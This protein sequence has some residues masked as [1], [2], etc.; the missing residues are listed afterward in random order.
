MKPVP[1]VMSVAEH[2]GW[3]HV[4]CVAASGAVP[5]VIVRRRVALIDEG[6][7]TQPY[8]HDSTALREDAANALIAKVRKSIAAR[9]SEALT[10]IAAEVSPPHHV[11]ALAIRKPP[12]DDLPASIASVRVS[13]KLQCAADGMMYQL[14]CVRAARQQGLD[15]HMYVRGEELAWAADRLG[16]TPGQVETFVSKAG[17]PAGPPWMQEHRQAFAAGIAVLAEHAR[18]RISIAPKF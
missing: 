15:V 18:I 16:V 3:A 1:C 2:T 5:G 6:L 11:V 10:R 8:E 13:Y 4:L 7:P 12:F 14:A 17:R 9:S